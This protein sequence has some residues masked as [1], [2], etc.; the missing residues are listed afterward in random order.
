MLYSIDTSQKITSI[1]HEN[2]YKICLSRLSQDELEAIKDALN[3]MID[4]DIA[5]GTDI[6]TSSWM[7]GSDWENTPF[8]MIYEKAA[9]LDTVL[10]AKFFGLLVWVVFMERPEIWSFGRFEKDGQPIAGLTY[11]RLRNI[12]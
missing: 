7:P 11:F 12:Q 2:E 8:Q 3:T 6:Q 1:P 4:E 5:K 10:S 9:K